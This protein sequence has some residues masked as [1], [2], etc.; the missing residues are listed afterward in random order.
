MR[1]LCADLEKQA[2]SGSL[3]N[4]PRLIEDIEKQFGMVRLVLEKELPANAA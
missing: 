3:E 2:A 1:D 4:A